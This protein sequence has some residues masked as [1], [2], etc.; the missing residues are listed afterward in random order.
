MLRES[1]ERCFSRATA[2]V[3]ASRSSCRY[4]KRNGCSSGDQRRDGGETYSFVPRNFSRRSGPE[5]AA[6][7]SL[8]KRESL[9]SPSPYQLG[10]KDPRRTTTCT[11]CRDRALPR[12]RRYA[13]DAYAPSRR[14]GRRTVRRALVNVRRRAVA[15]PTATKNAVKT[16]FVSRVRRRESIPKSR[17]SE[18]RIL[19]FS[20]P[21]CLSFSLCGE[22]S[23]GGSSTSPTRIVY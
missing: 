2:L 13:A 8:A 14:T 4:V 9:T 22:G 12:H 10:A 20:L 11:R 5:R 23:R 18:K 3:S 6:H 19:C 21:F 15:R 17:S 16:V 1:R 7:D